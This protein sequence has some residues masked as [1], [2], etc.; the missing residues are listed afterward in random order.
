MRTRM[1]KNDNLTAST[2][3]FMPPNLVNVQQYMLPKLLYIQAPL[4]LQ[5][6]SPSFIKSE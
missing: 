3:S 5:H 1:A 4:P 6:G 2:I